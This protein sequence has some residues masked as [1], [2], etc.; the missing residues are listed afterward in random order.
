MLFVLTIILVLAMIDRLSLT[1]LVDP[2][3]NDLNIS[4]LQISLLLGLSFAL[5]FSLFGLPAGYLVDKY[6]RRTLMTVSGIVWSVMTIAAAFAPSFEWLFAS[7][8]GIGFGEAILSPCAYSMIRDAFPPRQQPMAFGI[9]NAGGPVGAGLAVVLVGYLSG[10][11][12]LYLPGGLDIGANWRSALLLIGLL[13]LMSVLLLATIREPSRRLDP[14]T[15][16]KEDP[17]VKATARFLK[18]RWPV[19][20][21]MFAATAL[22][23]IAALSIAA[24][25]PTGLSRLFDQPIDAISRP[26][27]T[28][29]IFAPIAGIIFAVFTLTSLLRKA[30]IH[31]AA[32]IGATAMAVSAIALA[33]AILS[34]WMPISWIAIAIVAFL[35]PWIGVVVATMIARF[36]PGRMMGKVSAINFLMLGLVGMTGGPTLVPVL[37]MLFFSG[38]SAIAYGIVLTGGLAYLFSAAAL[39][40]AGTNSGEKD[41]EA[42]TAPKPA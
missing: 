13:S 29:Q 26:L 9:H 24:W 20:V 34:P 3:K 28:I 18:S 15:A 2:I 17:G 16:D 38:A 21:S 5:P 35:H 4:D 1:L 14:L 25:L 42:G 36:T 32:F 8:A 7:R 23:G 12:H 6:S 37:A 22:F 39:Y 40:F 19:Y 33:T 41:S 11:A 30:P 27:G 31:A 10:M